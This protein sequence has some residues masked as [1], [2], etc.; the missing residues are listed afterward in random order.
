MAKKTKN[1]GFIINAG[2]IGGYTVCPEAWRLWAMANVTPI[3]TSRTHQGREL[4]REWASNYSE[5]LQLSR[6]TKHLLLLLALAVV[7]Y[8]IR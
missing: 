8:L 5:V 4:H 6:Y 3:E 2:E 7:A 1:G